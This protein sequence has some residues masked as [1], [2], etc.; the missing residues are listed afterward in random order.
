MRILITET[1]KTNK[2]VRV[3]LYN[4]IIE[5]GHKVYFIH[6]GNEEIQTC[7]KETTELKM[8]ITVERN[9]MNPFK[10]LKLLFAERRLI[11]ENNIDTIL[12]YG[13]KTIPRVVIA[14]RLSGVKNI[15]CVVNGSGNLVMGNN[16]KKKLLRVMAYPMLVV[17]FRLADKVFFQNNDDYKQFLKMHIAC[18]KN[19]DRINGSGVNLEKY[20]ECKIYN[21]DS[22]LLITRL[23]GEKG[24]NEFIKAARIVKKKYPEV[25]F[26]L[27]GPNDDMS[28]G[29]D[30]EIFNTAV[31]DG[32]INYHGETENVGKFIEECSVF[33]YPSYYR[34]GVPRVVLEAMAIGRPIITTSSPGCK[35]TV[36]DGRNG[37]LVEPQNE[38]VVAE[39]IIWMIEHRLETLKM[40]KQSRLICEKEFDVNEVNKK[41]LVDV[42]NR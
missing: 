31:N 30:W 41:L 6:R 3:E 37:F 22:F 11:Q 4:S 23:T 13:I 21:K 36:V 42:L 34:E 29:I 20:S 1:T 17:A 35:E 8:P 27:V 25:R 28:N 19:S 12:V 38:K 18:K 7:I 5:Q 15:V 40:G 24:V 9:N 26:N 39:K 2:R 16:I 33:V 32:I 14:G 10:E